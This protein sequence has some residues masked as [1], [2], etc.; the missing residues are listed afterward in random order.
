[1]RDDV[2][3]VPYNKT[4]NFI[5]PFGIIENIKDAVGLQKSY[6]IF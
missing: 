2:G 4:W 1:M 5:E 6:G 3:I